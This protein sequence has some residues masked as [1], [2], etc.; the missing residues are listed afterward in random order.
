MNDVEMLHGTKLI[1]EL[2]NL[3]VLDFDAIVSYDHAIQHCDDP[4]AHRDLQLFR[5]DHVR[6]IDHLSKV[7]R[8]CEGTPIEPHRDLKGV[9]LEG[10]TTLRSLGGTLPALRAMRTNEQIT[11]RIYRKAASVALAPI[12]RVV[13]DENYADEQRH[14]A[15]IQAHIE[16]MS[17]TAVVTTSSI[18]TPIPFDDRDTIPTTR[19][20]R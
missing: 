11:N 3:I 20:T 1:H 19:R 18:P 2:N 7:I 14:L 13:I 5:D 8:S 16:R 17:G 9:V 15:V 12:A 4:R 6:H 10:L